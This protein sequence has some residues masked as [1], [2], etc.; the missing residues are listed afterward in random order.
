MPKRFTLDASVAAKWFNNEDL[1]DKA[2]QIRDAFVHGKINLLAPEQL[3]YEV[4]NSIWKN[5]APTAEEAAKAV[6]NLI[7][8][9]IELIHLNPRLAASAMKTARESHITFYD[10]AYIALADRY[11]APLISTDTEILAKS[12]K[13]SM[14][15]KDLQMTS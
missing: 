6:E 5:K 11:E 1:T 15:L 13:N 7:D 4:G 10:A 2:L 3:I 8:L 12:S 14:H 9:Q